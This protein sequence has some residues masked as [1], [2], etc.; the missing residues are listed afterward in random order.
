MRHAARSHSRSSASWLCRSRRRSHSSSTRRCASP[1]AAG[2]LPCCRRPTAPGRSWWD[3][4]C[5]RTKR[6]SSTPTPASR[7][8]LAPDRPVREVTGAVLKAVGDL[9]GAVQI[10]PI[11]QEVPWSVPLDEDDEHACYD[12]DQVARY[13]T[14]ATR[15]ALVLA[16]IR[17]PYRGRS[18]P[19]NAW[20]GSFDLAVNLFSGHPADPPL[21]DFIMRNSMDAEVVAA[22]RHPAAES[23]ADGGHP[24][25]G[26]P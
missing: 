26:K 23:G 8:A 22:G 15:A 6:S 20:W 17:A 13:F 18:T 9:G 2:R 19:V 14:V 11:P 16:A 10:N 3:S 12:P 1:R 25:V 7:I 4:I 24:A 21:D 5:T